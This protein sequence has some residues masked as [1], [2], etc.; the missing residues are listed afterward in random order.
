MHV[1]VIGDWV[2]ECGDFDV[3]EEEESPK[4]GE[5]ADTIYRREYIS[6]TSVGG[7]CQYK[8]S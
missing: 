2:P 3:A 4:G 8:D 5:D 1:F 7:Q 6:R